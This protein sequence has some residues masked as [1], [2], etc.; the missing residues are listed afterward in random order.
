MAWRRHERA[1]PH[2]IATFHSGL[3]RGQGAPDLMFWL[4]DP[5]SA[6]PAFYLD[7]ILLKPRSR[8][9]VRLRSADPADPPRIELPGLREPSDVDRLAEGYRRAL[10]VASRPEL[11]RRCDGPRPS[12]PHD[13]DEL[14]QVI[15]ANAYSIPHVVGTC[16]M[17]PSPDEGAVVDASG[18]VHGTERLSVVDASIIPDAPSGFPHLVTIMMAERLAERIASHQAIAP[19]MNRGF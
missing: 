19:W 8:G 10:E 6:S 2:S 4:T 7:P 11:R 18:S 3:S 16:A 14:R 1:D 12:A 13:P 15:R 17:G 9:T 5:D